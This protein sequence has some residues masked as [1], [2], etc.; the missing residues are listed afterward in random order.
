MKKKNILKLISVIKMIIYIKNKII[1]N[2][3]II[4]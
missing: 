4:N 2:I 1:F 3:I